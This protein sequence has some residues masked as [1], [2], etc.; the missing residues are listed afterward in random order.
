MGE[1]KVPVTHKLLKILS[2][3]ATDKEKHEEKGEEKSR[4]RKRI[5]KAA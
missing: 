5:E 1:A 4:I 3:L 2:S